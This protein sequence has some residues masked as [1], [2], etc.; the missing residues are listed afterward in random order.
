M[1][2]IFA[3]ATPRGK[4]GVAVVRISGPEAIEAGATLCGS[5]PSSRRAGLRRVVYQGEVLDEALVL[6]F[7]APNSFTGEHVVELHLHGSTAV[8]SKVLRVLSQVKGLRPAEAGEFTRQA[9]ENDQLDLS[10][11]EALADL[12]DAETES[13]IR[14]AQRVFEGA[15]GERVLEWRAGLVRAAALIEATIDFVDEDVPVD[16]YPEVHSLIDPVVR[17][18][19]KELAGVT[20]AERI[21]DGFEVAIIGRPNVGKSTLLNALSGRDA[22]ITSDVAGTT[23]DVVEVRME[24]R[25]LP[26]TL[27]DTAGL[28][29][30]DNIVE[31]LGIERAMSRADSADLRVVLLESDS[32]ELPIELR[33]D[34]IVRVAK[35]DTGNGGTLSARSGDGVDALLSEVGEVLGQRSSGAGL[36]IRER[37]RIGME[38][39]KMSLDSAKNRL[40]A[41]SELTELIANDLRDA[42]SALD[43]LIGKVD[44]EHVLDEIFSSF[45]IGK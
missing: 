9:L 32:E 1:D 10:Q 35:S 36:A 42:V 23:R 25:G 18:L 13:Q 20:A 31:N 7:P 43:S 27:L 15:L 19:E 44:V 41:G 11:V 34:D 40:D 28:R 16:V 39:A 5:L 22:A 3:L 17:S 45:C 21:R 4:S 14:Q 26:V 12:I 2:T 29:E 38:Q 30:T 33:A 37:H 8:V 6:V 24:I